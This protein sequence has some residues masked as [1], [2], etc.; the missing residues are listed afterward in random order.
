MNN[1]TKKSY[2]SFPWQ[3]RA[4]FLCDAGVRLILSNS[5]VQARNNDYL[6][7][8]CRYSNVMK[9]RGFIYVMIVEYFLRSSDHDHLAV[10]TS[11]P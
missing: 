2:L 10:E 8:Y 5:R 9:R 4:L 3:S 6:W 11:T 7:Q 1:K